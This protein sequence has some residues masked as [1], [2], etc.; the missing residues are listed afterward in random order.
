MASTRR[1]K[2]A[3]GTVLRPLARNLKS[4]NNISDLCGV[5]LSG[6]A[7]AF[8]VKTEKGPLRK[9][10]FGVKDITA[11][12]EI[13]EREDRPFEFLYVGSDVCHS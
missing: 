4:F 11:F 6:D 7:P 3:D 12:A 1:R 10:E 9:F 5:F 8:L 13:R 2:A